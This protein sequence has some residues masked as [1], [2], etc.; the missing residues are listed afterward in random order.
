MD[1]QQVAVEQAAPVEVATA[2]PETEQQQ[3]PEA[4]PAEQEQ[5]PKTFSQ[6]ELD[7][8]IAKRLDRERRKWER[9]QAAQVAERQVVQQPA[10]TE[11]PQDPVALAERIVAQREAAKQQAEIVEA[12]HDREEAAREKYDDFQQV[13]YNPSLRITEVMAQTIQA[14][15]QGP[16]IAY[17]LGS[18]PKEADRISRLNPFLQAKEI[19][20][21]EARLI[22]EPPARRTTKAPEPIAPIQ[23]RASGSTFDTTDPRSLKS[24]STS[25]WI[26]AERQRQ[27]RKLEAQRNR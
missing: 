19:G 6:E 10:E 22:A 21:I 4:T 14:S 1:E 2:A 24:M 17:F 27:I 12:Y 11:Q 13:A 9:E 3:T 8:A 5:A 26:A 15:E 7:K 20:R 16:D 25:E 18:N 23:S